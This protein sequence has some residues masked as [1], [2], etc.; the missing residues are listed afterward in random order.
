M[1]ILRE[2]RSSLRLL[3]VGTLG[4]VQVIEMTREELCLAAAGY[5]S[6]ARLLLEPGLGHFKPVEAEAM[7][8]RAL[9]LIREA[10]G[11]DP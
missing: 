2:L 4:G 6:K 3:R 10:L 7:V 8:A 1:G 9:D 11:K 5:L